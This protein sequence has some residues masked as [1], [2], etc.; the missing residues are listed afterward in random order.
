MTPS[1]TLGKDTAKGSRSKQRDA[2]SRD[3]ARS[4]RGLHLN[5]PHPSSCHLLITSDQ[6]GPCKTESAREWGLPSFSVHID[7]RS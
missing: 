1:G 7:G 6:V 5:G 2:A 3:Q 4:K